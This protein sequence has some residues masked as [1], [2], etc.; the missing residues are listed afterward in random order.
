[1]DQLPACVG[2]GWGWGLLPASSYKAPV[3]KGR[4]LLQATTVQHDGGSQN[5]TRRIAQ[6][7]ELAGMT[8]RQED[9]A[10][11]DEQAEEKGRQHGKA[12]PLRQPAVYCTG[13]H[14]KT[15]GNR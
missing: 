6:Q 2:Y 12:E 3:G 8:G 11:F 14:R 5:G 4:R 10:N 15:R 1:M 13:K 7:I 9:L